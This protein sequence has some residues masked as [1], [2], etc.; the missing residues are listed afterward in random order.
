MA[1]PTNME[2]AKYLKIE[3][4]VQEDAEELAFLDE[5]IEVA[6]EDLAGSGI[7]N[8]D[9]HRY[10]MAIK[11]LVANFYEERRPQVVGTITS[12]LNYSLERII[13]QLKAEE[14]PLDEEL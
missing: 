4:I 2:V 3:D 12:N 14:I 9:T 8:Q 7:K 13:L 6:A 1:L 10:G 5:L 11:L